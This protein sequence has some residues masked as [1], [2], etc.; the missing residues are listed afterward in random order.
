MKRILLISLALIFMCYSGCLALES[1]FRHIRGYKTEI[2]DILLN[3]YPMP[4]GSDVKIRVYTPYAP[5]SVTYVFNKNTKYTLTREGNYWRGTIRPPLD[6]Q[7]GWNLSFIYIKYRR[8]DLDKAGMQKITAFFKKMFAS[9]KLTEYKDDVVVEGKIWIR[10]FQ[11]SSLT[12]MTFVSSLE[13]ALTGEAFLITQALSTS[14]A[15]STAEVAVTPE[16]EPLRIK[17]SKTLNFLSRSV[18][19]S[20]EGFL[21][22]YTREESLRLNIS[23]KVDRETD[24]D[25]NFISTSTSGTTTTTQN[26]EKISILIRRASTEVYYGDFIGDF[27]ETEFARMNKSL[28]GIKVTGNYDRWGF[29]AL[30]STPRGQAKY[31]KAYGDGTQGPYNLGAAPVVVD[32][33][34][35]YLNGMEQRRGDDYTIDYQAGTVTFRRGVVISTSI[36]EAYFDWRENLYQHETVGLRYKQD[37]ND[38]LK[39]GVTYLSD[40]DNLYKAS[41]IR[42]TLSAT[43]EPTSHFL[44]GVD[45]S[46]KIGNTAIDSEIAYSNRD[47]NI[48]E[49]GENRSIGKAFKMSTV[50]DLNPVSLSTRFK[51]VGPSFMSI[52]DASAKQD[53]WQWGGILGYRPNSIYYAELNSAYDK[54]MLSGTRYLTTDQGVKSKFTPE[55]L[56]SLNYFYRQTEDSNDPVSA[57]EI[58]RLTTKHTADSSYRYGFMNSTIAGGLEERVSRSPS[59]ETT[60]YKTVNFG[61]STYGIEKLSASGNIELKETMLPDK[62]NP[63]T[64]TYNTNISATPTKDYFGSLSLQIIDDSAQGVTNVTD[65]NYRASPAANLMTDGK[66][67]ITAIK[68]D[69][70]GSQEAVSK[71]SGSFKLDY[72]PIDIVRCRYYYKPNFTFVENARTFSLNDYTN[73]GEITYTP[74]R[75]L[76]TSLIYKTQDIMNVD[77]TDPGLARESNRR[78]TYDT[79]FL[80]KSAPLRFLSLEFNYLTGD[81]LLTEQT[82]VGAS[83]YNGTKGNLKQYDLGAKTSLSEQFSIDSRY[84]WQNQ[85]QGSDTLTSNIDSLAQTIYLKGLWNYSENWTYFASYSYSESQD[86]LLTVDNT[87]YTIAPGFGLT[88]RLKDILRID[89]EYSRSVSY[90]GA[91]TQ[92]DTYSLKTKYDPNQYVHIN[93]RGTREISVEPNYKSSEILGSLEIV[94]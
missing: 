63:F 32:S 14:E 65:I 19:G 37:I 4:I 8:S 22:G 39:I 76:S 77:R 83:S 67:T 49:P 42:D 25:A 75:E 93:I 2:Y 33:D 84:T 82:S 16:V 47:L 85:L 12:R 34:R 38:D 73:Q 40:S 36:I 31:F 56:P 94:L 29:K 50:T 5:K 58:S 43:I 80:I 15:L 66:Y 44:V 20:K 1:E 88:Y 78:N 35:V 17:G 79:T 51:R 68:E 90:S 53:V 89:G 30:Y 21:S 64:K 41:E 13:S 61:S 92:V 48:L 52:G 7:E 72:R 46:G 23:G 45:G 91:S 18:E 57:A 26:E 10:A 69:F 60:T 70:N 87:T 74:I 28:S 86:R 24:V 27:N 6:L 62:T 9:M 11:A 54:Y 3:P 81:L 55:N 59:L 71:Q